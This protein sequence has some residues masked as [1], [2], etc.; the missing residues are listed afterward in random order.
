MGCTLNGAAAACSLD[1]GGPSRTRSPLAATMSP[2]TAS[3]PCETEDD[4]LSGRAVAGMGTV[5]RID[6][7]NAGCVSTATDEDSEGIADVQPF[8]NCTVRSGRNA[9]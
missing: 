1:G 3:P 6:C 9:S 7:D 5:S 8:V 2:S 4:R